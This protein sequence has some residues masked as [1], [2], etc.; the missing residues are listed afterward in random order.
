M[1]KTETKIK[2]SER[3]VLFMFLALIQVFLY[4]VYDSDCIRF[5]ST[6]IGRKT[7]LTQFLLLFLIYYWRR[8]ITKVFLFNSRN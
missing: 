5:L 8:C 7:L 2:L 1:R 4:F 6:F 3:N